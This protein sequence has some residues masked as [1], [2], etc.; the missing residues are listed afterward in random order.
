VVLTLL[1]G[2]TEGLASSALGTGTRQVALSSIEEPFASSGLRI[3]QGPLAQ[4][5]RD[6]RIQISTDI[7]RMSLCNTQEAPCSPAARAVRNIVAEARIR[8]GLARAGFIN[9]AINLAIKPT[10]DPFVWRSRWKLCR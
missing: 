2:A 7:A 3:V 8:D 1:A 4:I 9:R 6:V 10:I 5:W